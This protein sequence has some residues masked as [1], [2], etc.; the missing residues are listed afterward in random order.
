MRSDI[1]AVVPTIGERTLSDC[2]AALKRQSMPPVDIVVIKNVSPFVAAMNKGIRRVRTP[3]LVQCDAD[4]ILDPDCLATLRSAMTERTGVAIGYL[5]DEILGTIQAVKLYR[6][7]NLKRSPFGDSVTSDSDRITKMREEGSWISFASREGPDHGHAA[8]VLGCHRPHYDDPK[9]VYGKFS[10]MGSAVRNRNS[11]DEFQGVLHGLKKSAHPMAD[12]ALIAFCHGV[13]N[14]LEKC[15]HVGY[16]E[17]EDF[18]FLRA[19]MEQHGHENR[20]FAIT[21]LKGFD[22]AREVEKLQRG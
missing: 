11:Y 12:L 2:L 21:K 8:D 15:A 1:T 14:K 22:A 10:V 18:R 19:F 4:M 6:T 3:F 5:D 7:A 16:E 9:Y 20:L 17:T 13:F